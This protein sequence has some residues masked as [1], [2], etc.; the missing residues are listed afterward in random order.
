MSLLA[1][2]L[3]IRKLH[4]IIQTPFKMILVLFA[5]STNWLK[6]LK[7]YLLK[8][9]YVTVDVLNISSVSRVDDLLNPLEL[10]TCGVNESWDLGLHLLQTISFLTSNY[11]LFALKLMH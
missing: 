8:E 2:E 11:F 5:G 7:I 9:A 4:E 3:L 6:F 1:S 10:I